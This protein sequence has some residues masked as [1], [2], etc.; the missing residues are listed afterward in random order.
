MADCCLSQK[1][2]KAY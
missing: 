2:P 1:Y